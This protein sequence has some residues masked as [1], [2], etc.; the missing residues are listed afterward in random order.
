MSVFDEVSKASPPIKLHYTH[1]GHLRRI[2]K[3]SMPISRQTHLPPRRDANSPNQTGCEEVPDPQQQM[4]D[5]A[6]TKHPPKIQTS[7][8]HHDTDS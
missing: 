7:P 4:S 3:R 8:T 1:M 5:T 6:Q 2:S